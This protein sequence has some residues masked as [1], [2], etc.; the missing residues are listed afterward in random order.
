MSVNRENQRENEETCLR[1]KPPC[2]RLVSQAWGLL[3]RSPIVEENC[4]PV[5]AS[6]EN[7]FQVSRNVALRWA[8]L[9][10][11][12]RDKEP[13]DQSSSL[14]VSKCSTQARRLRRL[15]TIKSSVLATG[16]GIVEFDAGKVRRSDG[17]IIDSGPCPQVSGTLDHERACIGKEFEREITVG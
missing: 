1:R 9:A 12:I 4:Q 2:F 14:R 3:P 17:E 11:T 8:L 6:L 16:T 15:H 5:A 7:G 13:G 10:S